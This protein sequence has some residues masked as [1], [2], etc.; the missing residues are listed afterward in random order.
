[1][2]SA[3]HN[4]RTVNRRNVLKKLGAAGVVG[5]VGLPAGVSAEPNPSDV[6]I[7]K[8]LDKTHIQQ[9][10]DVV[11]TLSVEEAVVKQRELDGRTITHT[12]FQTNLGT[13][14]NTEIGN[15]VEAK[16]ELNLAQTPELRQKLPAE[17]RPI[18]AESTTFL[19]S[20][21]SSITIA[22]MA[23]DTELEQLEHA[24]EEDVISAVY[25]HNSSGF[26]VAAGTVNEDTANVQRYHV[27]ATGGDL[28]AASV[29]PVAS[30]EGSCVYTCTSCAGA[31]VSKGFCVS[32]CAAAMTGVGLGGCIACAFFTNLG[33]GSCGMCYNCFW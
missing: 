24:V 23:T 21:E 25:T 14:T 27:D 26:K 19:V 8:I 12:E 1:M 22:R 20:D 33:I 5:A 10:E 13:L 7:E 17:F 15:S 31:V 9:I 16:L 32:T 28:S 30:T 29:E 11:G 2:R 18:P 6:H 3:E 4:N